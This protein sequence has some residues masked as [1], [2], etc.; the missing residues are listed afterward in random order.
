MVKLQIFGYNG[1]ISMIRHG[2]MVKSRITFDAFVFEQK[3][4][5]FDFWLNANF[6]NAIF[7]ETVTGTQII[8]ANCMYPL[9]L[10]LIY[11]MKN[12]PYSRTKFGILPI[13]MRK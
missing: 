2:S 7:S 9:S 11:M 10:M 12:C 13:S 8:H 4:C 3:I 5:V 1:Q 6:K